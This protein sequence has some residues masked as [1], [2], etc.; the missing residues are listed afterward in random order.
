M[1]EG[2]IN[3]SKFTGPKD[4]CLCRCGAIFHSHTKWVLDAD[5]VVSQDPVRAADR[6]TICSEYHHRRRYGGSTHDYQNKTA[7]PL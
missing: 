4:E 2:E 1:Y 3:W 5:R 7:K 6:M